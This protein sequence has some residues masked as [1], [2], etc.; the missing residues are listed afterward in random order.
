[1][2]IANATLDRTI[3]LGFV[4][5]DRVTKVIFR[6]NTEWLSHG[7]GVFSIRVLRHGARQAYNATQV[8][9]DKEDMELIMTVTDIELSVKGAGEMQVVY[10]GDG[11]VKK[12]PIYRYN[13]FRALEGPVVDPPESSVIDE[14]IES[15]SG[16]KGTVQSMA[17]TVANHDSDIGDITDLQTDSKR[18]LVGAINEINGKIP[19]IDAELSDDSENP[20]QNKVIK[21]YVDANKL[22]NVRDGAGRGSVEEG[23]GT[24]SGEDK[25]AIYAHAEGSRS[26]ATGDYSHAEGYNTAASGKNSHAEGTGT[27]AVGVDA[28]AEGHYS[29]AEGNYSHAEG[30][31][32][33][34]G[35][36]SHAEGDSISS[37][38]NAHSEGFGSTASGLWSHAEG[39]STT[40]SGGDSHAEG[41]H[42]SAEG[43]HSHSEG[44]E[45]KALG[46]KSHAEGYFT[47]ANGEASHAEGR[48]SIARGDYSH[49]EGKGQAIGNCSHA[50]GTGSHARGAGS[51]A[52]GAAD[53]DGENSH[54]E[55]EGHAVGKNSHAEGFMAFANGEASHAGGIG[56]KANGIAQTVIG[57]SNKTHDGSSRAG[58]EKLFVIGNGD[59][60]QNI[61][62]DAHTLNRD[63]TAWYQKDVKAGGSDDANAAVS[64]VDLHA[65]VSD[66]V[67]VRVRPFEGEK[68]ISAET[69]EVVG[70]PSYVEDFVPFPGAESIG[71]G[72]FVVAYVKPKSGTEVSANTVTVEGAAA[73]MYFEGEIVVVARFEVAAMSQSVTINW[74]SYTET[75]VFKATDLAI[76]NLDQRVTFYVY[77]ADPYTT[78]EYTAAT[79]A[80]FVAGKKYYTKDGDDYV[81]AEVTA[82]ETVTEGYYVHSKVIISGLVRNVT[83]RLNEI[84]DCPMEF[85]LPEIDDETHGAWYEIRCRHAGSYSMTLTPPA[86]VKIAT[87][88]TQKE[89]AGINMINLHYTVIDGVKIWRFMNTHSSIPA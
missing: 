8:E 59:N 61:R 55:N 25:D 66:D 47:T 6:Y 54:A 3:M 24:T 36:S 68:P 63:G 65:T 76:R 84:V 12:S 26:K 39:A 62:S 82:G 16:L 71:S 89:T 38:A 72:W 75:F 5:E 21:T 74:G 33:A 79:D 77:D 19:D 4:G 2:R 28:H 49:A 51:H 22:N 20:V 86:G 32:K 31:A 41:S 46:S 56:T 29:N 15:L 27:S 30:S 67:R 14:I 64:L 13:V 42:T 9:V 87:E 83:Y 73:W 52:E 78:W 50:E 40:A 57:E 48:G 37:G 7:D 44:A 35:S 69:F 1:M 88:H 34:I 85:I 18:N 10:T 53:A 23:A 17:E 81:E 58:S 45:S 11:F 80:K 70:I 43:D 60:T